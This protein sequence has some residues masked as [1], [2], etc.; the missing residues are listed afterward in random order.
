MGFTFTVITLLLTRLD[1]PSSL[2]SQ[3]ML[4][5]LV[6]IFYLN[7]FITEHLN[8][9]TLYYCRRVPQRTRKIAVRTAMIIL[10]T[11][12]FGLAIPLMFLLFDLVYL[13]VVTTIIWC[14]TTLATLVLVYRPLF[15]YRKKHAG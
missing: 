11:A 4:L 1:N 14:I 13:S 6:I 12:L 2:N 3:L 9:E 5:F 7:A 15:K 8:V 10:S